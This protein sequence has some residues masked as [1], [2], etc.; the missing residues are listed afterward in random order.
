MHNMTGGCH[1]G[2][3]LV[4]MELGFAP[5]SFNPRACDCDFCRMHDACYVSDTR[6][7][8]RFQIKQE[9]DCAYYRQG[10]GIAQFLI[11]RNCA[12]LIGV[13]Y[14]AEPLLYAAVNARIFGA[15]ACFGSEQPAS[16]KHLS[17]TQ[18]V[19]RWREVWFSKVRIVYADR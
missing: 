18:K 19:E 6:G 10:S 7:S 3:V 5:N 13:L 17:E 4:H 16:P 12:V 8:V 15:A 11:C 2:N 9:H 14:R 1:C